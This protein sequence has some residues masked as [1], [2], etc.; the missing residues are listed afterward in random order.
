M[1]LTCQIMPKVLQ[2][3]DF[4]LIKLYNGTAFFIMSL[5]F[6]LIQHKFSPHISTAI[7]RQFSKN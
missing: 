4:T 1:F 6:E 2:F 3:G 5:C 7:P